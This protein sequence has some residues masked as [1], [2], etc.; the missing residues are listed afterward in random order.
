LGHIISEDGIAVDPEKIKEIVEW[1][2]PTNVAE[3]RSF[4]GITRYYRRFI[5]NFSKISFS[6]TSLQKKGIKFIWSQ[7][8][9]ES[10]NQLKEWLTTA[11]ILK[12]CQPL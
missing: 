6:I 4:M 3:I 5:E 12:V 10:F 9:Q 1:P 11:P 7:K 8:C 2:R